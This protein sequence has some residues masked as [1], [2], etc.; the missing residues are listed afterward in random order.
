M[1]QEAIKKITDSM[2]DCTEKRVPA[3]PIARYLVGKCGEDE[4]LA[5]LVMQEHKTLQKC[6]DFVY[7]QVKNHLNGASGWIEDNDVYMMALDYFSLDDAEL[8]RQKA[9]EEVKR[10]EERRKN[11]EERAKRMAE[12]KATPSKTTDS[13]QI[14]LFGGED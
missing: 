14:S 11:E 4:E 10:A 9:E 8:E 1:L 13:E 3:E 2:E 5:G 12:F 6:F 7:E